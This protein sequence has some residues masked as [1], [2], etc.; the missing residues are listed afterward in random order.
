MQIMIIPGPR[1][2]QQIHQIK[3]NHEMLSEEDWKSYVLDWSD[4]EEWLDA[5]YYACGESQ[6]ALAEQAEY[7][8]ERLIYDE[9]HYYAYRL[10]KLEIDF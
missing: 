10:A 1:D 2:E 6:E 8:H 4:D 5:L 7:F 9:H 3:R